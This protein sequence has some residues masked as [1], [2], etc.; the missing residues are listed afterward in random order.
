MKGKKEK[1]EKKIWLRRLILVWDHI[2]IIELWKE[3]ER[4]K[5]KWEKGRKISM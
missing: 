5:K 4:R 2:K 3:T 1:K